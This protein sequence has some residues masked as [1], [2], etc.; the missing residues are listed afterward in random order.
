MIKKIPIASIIIEG[1]QAR[2]ST[3][4]VT[5]QE[6]KELLDKKT[7]FPPIIVF[8]DGGK[9]YFI[10][11]G[12][13]RVLAAQDLERKEIEADIRKGSKQDALWFSAGANQAHGLKRTNEDKRKA[14]EIAF[15]LKPKLSDRSIAAHCGVSH[16]NVAKVREELIQL[17]ILPVECGKRDGADGK[18]RTV[19][20]KSTGKILPV[21]PPAEPARV[22]S[23]PIAPIAPPDAPQPKPATPPVRPVIL[24]K[25]GYPVPPQIHARW[26]EGR[27]EP[28]IMLVRV[29]E[30]REYIEARKSNILYGW[31]NFEAAL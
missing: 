2:E 20:E 12:I 8:N 10:G 31:F 27:N 3:N 29:N 18:K 14:V 16:P 9:E 19:K 23:A 1:L 22:E 28:P 6:Y 15:R 25:I 11:D 17:E 26:N 21:E 30:I 13:H 24:D 7:T 4:D 5:V